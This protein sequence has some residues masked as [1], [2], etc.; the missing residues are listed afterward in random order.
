MA[1]HDVCG[2]LIS[3]MGRMRWGFGRIFE[4][5]GGK[6]SSHTIFEVG[7]GSKVKILA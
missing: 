2:D 4:G 1:V 6:F 5:V 3:L 7:D